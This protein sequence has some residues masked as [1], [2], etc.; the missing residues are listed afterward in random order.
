MGYGTFTLMGKCIA[1]EFTFWG[2]FFRPKKRKML[3]RDSKRLIG[4]C[5][6][7]LALYDVQ[8][9]FS[10]ETRGC[11]VI[12]S[13]RVLFDPFLLLRGNSKEYKTVFVFL[14]VPRCFHIRSLSFISFL[15]CFSVKANSQSGPLADGPWT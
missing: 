13:L 15:N 8:Q 12:L 5:R 4:R 3:D 1:K 6:T 9:G 11:R 14:F 10:D 2:I 7:V